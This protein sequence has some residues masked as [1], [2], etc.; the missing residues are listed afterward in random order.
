M[1]SSTVCGETG[2]SLVLSP[3]MPSKDSSAR[4]AIPGTSAK[5]YVMPSSICGL[6]SCCVLTAGAQN[7][8]R[9]PMH[10]SICCFERSFPR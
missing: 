5:P 9:V 1:D 7:M 3:P 8:G 4:R 6:P 2:D 10:S